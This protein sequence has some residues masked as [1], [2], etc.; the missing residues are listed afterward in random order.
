M[1]TDFLLFMY[2]LENILM[3]LT[4]EEEGG[5]GGGGIEEPSFQMFANAVRNL[6]KTILSF[7]KLYYI[8]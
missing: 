1:G 2:R 4:K 3:I 7:F 8:F 6:I 5:G